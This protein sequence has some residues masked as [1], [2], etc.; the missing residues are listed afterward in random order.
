VEEVRS[1]EIG[2]RTYVVADVK[3]LDVDGTRTTAVGAALF[4]VAFL[5]LLPFHH[6]LADAGRTWWLG[7]CLAGSG[8]GLFG[9]AYCRHRRTRRARAQG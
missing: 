4:L 3:A 6:E 8:L 5:A 7:T 9:W 2:S 1:P